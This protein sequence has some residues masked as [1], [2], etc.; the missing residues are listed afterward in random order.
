MCVRISQFVQILFLHTHTSCA[1]FN[2]IAKEFSTNAES[3][4]EFAL[5]IFFSF[6]F[7][8]FFLQLLR[9]L[10]EAN[11]KFI[12]ELWNLIL[13]RRFLGFILTSVDF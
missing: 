11:V 9:H 5:P 7:F 13:A 3:A 1:Q 4:C 2:A 8:F 6:V 10:E 12:R